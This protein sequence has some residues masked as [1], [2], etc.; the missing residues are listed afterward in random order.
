MVEFN[1]LESSFAEND[2]GFLVDNKLDISWQHALAEMTNS[3]LG[4]H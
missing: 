1:Q 2:L 3:P 4:L